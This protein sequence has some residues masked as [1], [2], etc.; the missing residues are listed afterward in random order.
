MKTN[1]NMLRNA[2]IGY[3]L[4]D[5]ENDEEIEVF[6]SDLLQYGCISGMVRDLIYYKDTHAFYDWYYEDIE[7]LRYEWEEQTGESLVPR[8]DL[9]NW[10]AWFAFEET[11]YRIAQELGIEI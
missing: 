2:V 6:F 4:D 10:F 5:Y 9:K 11:A 1:E 8:G 3:I 7:E